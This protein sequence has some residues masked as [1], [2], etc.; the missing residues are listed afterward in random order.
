MA[1]HPQMKEAEASTKGGMP[2]PAALQ[3]NMPAVV[4]DPLDYGDDSGAGMDGVDRE[5]MRVPFVRVLQPKSPQVD[6]SAGGIIIKGAMPGML[7]HMATEEIWPGDGSV[8][9]VTCYREKDYV[10]WTPV[11]AGGGLVG[12]HAW[13]D[14]KINQ[15]RATQGRFGKLITP[16]K[17]E[18]SQT[19][20]LYGL[21]IPPDKVE[22]RVVIGF[23]STQIKKYQ[24]VI[25]RV[26]SLKF[27]VDGKTRQPPLYAWQWRIKTMA[28]KN[29]KGSWFGI[30]LE[31]AGE[32]SISSLLSR[33]DPVFHRARDFFE[34]LKA[35]HVTADLTQ[36]GGKERDMDDVP[37]EE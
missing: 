1:K 35:G 4:S 7:I 15:L 6:A 30:R 14:S 17:T 13:N 36:M 5:E 34:L 25:D 8:K 33:T 27:V 3:E 31:P 12:R 10:E 24:S 9:F 19:F 32:T 28:E 22:R 18:I 11:N 16:E 37:Y 29:K 20:Y 2:A 23:T 21:L 26:D